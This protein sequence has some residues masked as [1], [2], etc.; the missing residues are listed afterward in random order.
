M[1]TCAHNLSAKGSKQICKL[2]TELFYH[3]GG[4]DELQVHKHNTSSAGKVH[5]IRI[6][7][8]SG[9]YLSGEAGTLF[10]PNNVAVY[11]VLVPMVIL[12]DTAYLLLAWLMKPY[13][14]NTASARRRFSY[15]LSSCVTV[16]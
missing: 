9:L 3:S 10:H 8:R 13:P 11:R 4:L 16:A 1:A 5:D 6:F 14:D 7:R 12:E 2:Q 15:M